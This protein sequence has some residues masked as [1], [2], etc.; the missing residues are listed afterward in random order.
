MHGWFPLLCYWLLLLLP[1]G[2]L[3]TAGARYFDLQKQYK[4]H[5]LNHIVDSQSAQD[6]LGYQLPFR[7]CSAVDGTAA[8]K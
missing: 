4:Q 1:L 2:L 3:L 7:T 6:L 5:D 8:V